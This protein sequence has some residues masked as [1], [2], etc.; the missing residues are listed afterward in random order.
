MLR[1]LSMGVQPDLAASLPDADAAIAR[2]LDLSAPPPALLRLRLRPTTTPPRRPGAITQPI[3]FWLEQMQS[4]PRLVEERLVWFWHDH[5]ATSVAKV[6]V[7]Y[8][9]WQQH[10]LL[11]EH[12]TGN[13]AELLHAVSKDPAMLW[14]LDGV[15]NTTRAAKRELRARSDGAVH[16]R[17]WATT[18]SR[19]WSRRRARSPVGSV[20]ILGLPQLAALSAVAPPWNATFLAARH[21]N[22]TKTLLGTTANL[23][24]DGALDVLLNHDATATRIAGKLYTELVGVAPSDED[25]EATRQDV[26]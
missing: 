17:S 6:R 3:T 15:T 25:R 5:F 11:R 14:Y 7:P 2:A 13:F 10:L 18:R 26:P 1:R 20:N 19:T 9:M 24:L 4:N 21:D 22:G 23:D 8:L 12:A 16:D